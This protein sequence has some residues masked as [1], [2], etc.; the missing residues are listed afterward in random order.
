MSMRQETHNLI[1]RL[2][3]SSLSLILQIIKNMSPDF[4]SGRVIEN[5]LPH[6]RSLSKLEQISELHDNW[7][8][9]GAKAFSKPHIE[10]IRSLISE[11]EY[12]PEVFPTACGS[13][14]LEYDKPD[15]RHIEIEIPE[16]GPA[17]YL[18]DSPDGSGRSGFIEADAHDVNELI[19]SFY[20]STL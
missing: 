17:E 13:I 12:E 20:G 16:N 7:N 6:G 18:Y 9:N 14:Q 5:P 2:P 4:F 10:K 11:L 19:R 1:D 3:D 8:E 15:G